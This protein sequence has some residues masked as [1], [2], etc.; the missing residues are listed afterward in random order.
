MSKARGF[1]RDSLVIFADLIDFP[2]DWEPEVKAL[3]A[4]VDEMFDPK[5]IKLKGKYDRK[6]MFL[7]V[8][9][10]VSGEQV[11]ITQAKNDFIRD[12]IKSQDKKIAFLKK[13]QAANFS[14][15]TL[16]FEMLEKYAPIAQQFL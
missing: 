8:L 7:E 4:K 9:V 16:L 11:Q 2:F 3:M 12:Y 6:K 10:E 15:D 14:A 5:K 13:A 1:R